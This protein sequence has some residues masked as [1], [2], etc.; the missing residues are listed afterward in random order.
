MPLADLMPIQAKERNYIIWQNRSVRF[1]IAARLLYLHEQFSAAAFCSNQ[2]LE[3]LLKGTLVYWDT[4]FKPEKAKHRMER[5]LNSVRNKANGGSS[6]EMPAYFYEEKR[7]QSLSRYPSNGKGLGIPASFL[8]DMDTAFINLVCLVPFQFN[9]ELVHIL[10]G[11]R[12]K[13]LKILRC[14]N[15]RIR[16]LRKALAIPNI[17]PSRANRK[18]QL[19]ERER[20]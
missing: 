12:N 11:S 7:Y 10:R 1:Y 15:K 16:K 9:S 17:N 8:E 14:K 18:P 4:S 6:F 2:A 13:E 3:S 19:S 5:M 20:V